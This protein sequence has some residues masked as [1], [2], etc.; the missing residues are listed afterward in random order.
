MKIYYDCYNSFFICHT[1]IIILSGNGSIIKYCLLLF[2]FPF[3]FSISFL[4]I[5]ILLYFYYFI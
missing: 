2:L 5:L 1:N 3:I 4:F